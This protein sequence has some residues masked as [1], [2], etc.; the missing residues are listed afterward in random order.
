MYSKANKVANEG[1]EET[2]TGRTPTPIKPTGRALGLKYDKQERSWSFETPLPQMDGRKKVEQVRR[3]L[4]PSALVLYQGE[5][6]LRNAERG[7]TR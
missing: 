2:V 4:T 5:A 3:P 1:Q 6:T 7:M